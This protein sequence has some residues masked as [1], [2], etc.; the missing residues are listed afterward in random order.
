MANEVINEPIS[1]NLTTVDTVLTGNNEVMI[2]QRLEF[3]Q[4][5]ILNTPTTVNMTRT[6][7][8]ETLTTKSKSSGRCIC[9]C[10]GTASVLP[11]NAN[12]AKQKNKG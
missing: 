5:N 2:E 4:K 8:K 12:I 1:E 11:S 3:D 9:F 6:I 10:I 7:I